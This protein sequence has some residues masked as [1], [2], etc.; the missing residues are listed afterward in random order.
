M[1]DGVMRAHTLPCW[2]WGE[3]DTSGNTLSGDVVIS[4]CSNSYIHSNSRLVAAIGLDEITVVETADAVLVAPVSKAEEVKQMVTD[5]SVT[6]SQLVNANRKVHRPWGT[7]D[8]LMTEYNF[9]V[10]I[11]EINPGGILSLQSHNHRAE[12]WSIVEG[13][14]RVTLDGDVIEKTA[15]EA[16][17][18]PLGAQHR[19]ENPRD[20]TLKIVEVQIGSL[21]EEEDIVRYADEY[22]R[23]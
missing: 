14:A 23:L 15:G 18:V 7:F 8:V 3:Q 22:G 6:R 16:I 5:L 12:T 20:E 10:K 11:L 19:I 9:L 13:T 2:I 17:C 4:D 1:P 21:L